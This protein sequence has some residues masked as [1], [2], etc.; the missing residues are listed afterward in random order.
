MKVA[1]QF[2]SHS[3]IRLPQHACLSSLE[4]NDGGVYVQNDTL[5]LTRDIPTR[6]GWLVEPF[7]T[8]IPK[9]TVQFT[10]QA[11]GRLFSTALAD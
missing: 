6:L 10:L 9:E 1:G 11:T 5:T 3:G 7:I 2:P 8:N 4:E